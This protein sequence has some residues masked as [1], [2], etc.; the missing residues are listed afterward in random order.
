MANKSEPLFNAGAAVY[1]SFSF[2]RGPAE[3][4]VEKA[5]LSP[6][7]RVLDVACGSGWASLKAVRLVGN[8]GYVT[9]IDIADKLLDVARQK[10][11]SD[12]L[13]NIEFL[14]GDAHKLVFEDNT[15]DTLICASSLF[16]FNNMTR[17]LKECYRVL[18][19][20]GIMIFS[21]FGEGVFQPVTGFINDHL[22]KH[23]KNMLSHSPISVTDS[24]E[25]CREIFINAG[26]E[27]VI[28]TE[29]CL[30]LLLPDKEECWRQI[31]GSLIV[32]PRL[33]GLSADDYGLLKKEI[34]SELD[35][36]DYSHGIPV[37]V[38][39]IFCTVRK[40]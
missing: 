23:G 15:Y 14:V 31:S 19:T 35:Q 13:T 20:G 29:E 3:L 34:L 2:L 37:D 16:L 30:E 33:T 24:N 22:K 5:Q 36:P 12:G 27:N 28:I 4:T 18:K 11:E 38:P 40:L 26:F 1:D 8:N 9:G 21:T 7:Q 32:R 25:K 10:A 39:V 17:V 6:G